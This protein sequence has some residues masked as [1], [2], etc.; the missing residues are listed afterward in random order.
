VY[1]LNKSDSE[2][3]EVVQRLQK[4]QGTDAILRKGASG[5]E[6]RALQLRL[7]K[8]GFFTGTVDDYFGEST[9]AAVIKFQTSKGVLADG[10]VGRGTKKLLDDSNDIAGSRPSVTGR[11]TADVVKEMFPSAPIENIRANLPGILRAL[12]DAGLS[13][14]DMVLMALVTVY[15]ETAGTFAPVTEL[16]SRFNTSPDGHPFDLYDNKKGLGNQGPPDGERFKGRGYIQLTGRAGYEHYDQAIGLKGQLTTYPE[17][18]S[19]PPIAAK[20]FAQ[21]L[22]EVAGRMRQALNQGDLGLA[23]RPLHG[24]RLAGPQLDQLQKAFDKGKSLIQ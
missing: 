19:D 1:R 10:I 17:F 20:I 7:Q 12:E 24:S 9:E 18:A 4:L 8:S 6:V 3:D 13:D 16:K 23:F 21:T 15:F 11:V 22:K 5:P 14:Q 2:A